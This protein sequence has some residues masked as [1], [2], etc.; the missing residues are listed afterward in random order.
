MR[1][2]SLIVLATMSML[3]FNTSAFALGAAS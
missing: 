3:A 2:I 1:K